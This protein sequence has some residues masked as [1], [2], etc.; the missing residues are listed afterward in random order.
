MRSILHIVTTPDDTLAESI[1]SRQRSLPDQ[2]VKV[3]DLTVPHPD[4]RALLEVIFTADSI[5]MW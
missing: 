2:E 4:Y 3:A 5:Q 1:I